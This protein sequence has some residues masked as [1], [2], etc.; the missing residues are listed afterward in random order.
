[1]DQ[2]EA[3][4]AAMA[5]LGPFEPA[6]HLAVAVSGGSDSLALLLL[7]RDWLG[8]KNGRLTALSVDHALRP[9][10]AAECRQVGALVDALNGDPAAPQIEHHILTWE[11]EKPA[12]G[13]MAAARAARYRLLAAW[14]RT[15]DV[16]HL[17]VA[18]HADDQAETVLMRADHG[19]GASGL[20]GM[21]ALRCLEGV[22]LLRPVLGWRKEA[23]MAG[24]RAA[25]ISWIEDPS[26]RA[27]KFERI[28]WRQRLGPGAEIGSLLRE[29][30]AAGQG[31]DRL[32]R[33]AAAWFAEYGRIDPAGYTTLPIPLLL[34]T[35]DNLLGQILRQ[36][37]ALVGAAVFPPAPAALEHVIGKLKAMRQNDELTVTLAGCLLGARQGRLRICREAKACAGAVPLQENQPVLWDRRFRAT[38]RWA[39][40]RWACLGERDGEGL[41]QAFVAAVGKYGLRGQSLTPDLKAIPQPAR[42]ALP[43]LWQQGQML[44]VGTVRA[45]GSPVLAEEQGAGQPLYTLDVS[46]LPSQPATSCG[47]TVVPPPRHTM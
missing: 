5:A 41:L 10:A 44:A 46:F 32:E 37:L 29:T 9:E 27:E 4:A 16:L 14:C 28:R 42:E 38:V 22:R 43:A 33:A 17:A 23:L 8:A 15:H 3:F 2:R 12:T 13:L 35:G 26:N 21:S 30:L 6:P 1:M 39:A 40:L 20:A 47:F 34:A 25:G 45:Q 36:A 19:S 18:H 11:G 31:R 7:L 24:L